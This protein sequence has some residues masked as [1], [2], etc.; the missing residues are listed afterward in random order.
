MSRYGSKRIKATR[1]VQQ[2]A[3]PFFESPGRRYR[4]ITIAITMLGL[5]ISS[6]DS[7][8]VVLALPVM[9]RDLH[10]DIAGMVWVIMAYLLVITIL[11]T[12]VGRLGDI[13]GRIRVYNLGFGLFTI[14]SLLCA[15]APNGPT[16]IVFRVLQGIGG[17]FVSSNVGAI[18]ADTFPPSERGKAYGLAGI[19]YTGGAV[20]GI[21]VGGALITF[22]TWRFIFL[23][24][25]PIGTTATIAGF[26]LLKERSPRLKE[27]LDISGMALF[28]AGL[29]VFLYLLNEVTGPGWSGYDGFQLALAAALL[30][31]FVWRERR[32]ATPLLDFALLRIR[33]LTASVSASF[34]QAVSSFAVIFL[35]IMYLQGPRGLSPWNA[36]LFLVPGFILGGCVAPFTG[37][38]S[39]RLGARVVASLGLA[40]QGVGILVFSTLGLASSLYVVV[41]GAVFNGAGNEAFY[42]ANNSAVMAS[43]PP[44]AYGVSAGLL[45]T[46]TNIGQ[47]SSFALALLIASLSI[48]RNVAFAIFL[49]SGGISTQLSAS[50]VQGMHVALLAS[51]SLI[52][53]AFVLS[54]LAGK[55]SRT[56]RAS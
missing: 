29:F 36:S 2:Q 23:I 53:V 1:A 46:F 52:V 38:L 34:F 18:I 40:L 48:P 33:V 3:A 19:G 35:V 11:S 51:M 55:E 8:A 42:P 49:G 37:A 17:A 41:A 21:M 10:S 27:S 4:A 31:A 44:R 15:L 24:N 54:V 5:A 56:V 16:L 12:Q 45:R 30:L 32:A 7:T 22:A 26:L 20:L 13:L 6:V 43:A 39:D 47:V 28:G 25:L 50:Y 9:A 14:G